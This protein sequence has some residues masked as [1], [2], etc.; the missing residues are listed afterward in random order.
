MPPVSSPRG[1]E[2]ACLYECSECFS[3][4]CYL[5]FRSPFKDLLRLLAHEGVLKT[6]EKHSQ[7]MAF[8]GSSRP[9]K[10]ASCTGGPLGPIG[11]SGNPPKPE[12]SRTAPIE[13]RA[14]GGR[15]VFQLATEIARPCSRD[16]SPC[17]ARRF[18]IW[19]CRA[20]SSSAMPA[21]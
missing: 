7:R 13:S 10:K 17:A 18:G 4:F 6:L 2:S 16:R 21:A 3:D 11:S 14:R 1:T 9:L 20:F 12:K 15:R 8:C 5:F 19:R